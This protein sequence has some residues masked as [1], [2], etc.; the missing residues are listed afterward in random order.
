MNPVSLILSLLFLGVFA[1]APSYA[2]LISQN[3]VYGHGS[4]TLDTDTGLQWLDPWLAIVQK[5]TQVS[6][7]LNSYAD[8]KSMLDEGRHFD[9]F[10]FAKRSEVEA[11]LYSSIGFS[12]DSSEMQNAYLA[13]HMISFFDSTLGHGDQDYFDSQL[14]DA[15]F[16]DDNSNDPMN[17]YVSYARYG[18][19]YTGTSPQFYTAP[20]H[21]IS[22]T[23]PYGFFLVRDTLVSVDEPAGLLLLG[24]GML[25]LFSRKQ[26]TH[27]HN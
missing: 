24:V 2:V 15:V 21:Y 8:V 14:L 12:T 3:S 25:A 26:R 5:D 6:S 20:D 11:L 4:L 1:S 22:N 7:Y 16:E 18:T 23:T 13:A 27:S 9:G 17:I 10:R 19:S